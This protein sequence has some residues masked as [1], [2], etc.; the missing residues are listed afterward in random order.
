MPIYEYR[1]EKGH[2]FEA[3]QHIIDPSLEK[4]KLCDAKATRCISRVNLPKG[5]GVYFFDRAH[6]N[7]DILHDPTLSD[8]ERSSIL[9]PVLNDL[10]K[11]RGQDQY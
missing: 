8:R 9:S 10:Q 3:F 7:R 4:C 2:L 11:N 6:G 5:A 1:C